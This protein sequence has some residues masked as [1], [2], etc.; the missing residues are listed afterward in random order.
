M[1]AADFESLCKYQM[2]FISVPR[3]A[4]KV[5]IQGLREV[6]ICAKVFWASCVDMLA[7]SSG[8]GYMY[9]W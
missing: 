7:R 3:C 1:Q 4:I 2:F 6:T 9:C 5:G 8:V